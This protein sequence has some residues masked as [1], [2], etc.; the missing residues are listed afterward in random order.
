[1]S[2]IPRQRDYIV[3]NGVYWE[4]SKPRAQA[5]LDEFTDAQLKRSGKHIADT[6]KYMETTGA[7]AVVAEHGKNAAQ[8]MNEE[9][10]KAYLSNTGAIAYRDLSLS[11]GIPRY[12]AALKEARPM[13]EIDPTMN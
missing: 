4:E 3:Y 7:D 9:Q 13:V 8:Y 10:L 1:M 5:A 2:G 6:G 11:T 12:L